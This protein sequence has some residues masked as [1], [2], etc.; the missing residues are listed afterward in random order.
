MQ[1]RAGWCTGR[2]EAVAAVGWL[3][4]MRMPEVAVVGW[5]A[6]MRMP[7]VAVVGWW[8]RMRMP[9]VA[10]TGSC[11]RMRMR[12]IAATRLPRC[13][14][15]A[16]GSRA[17]RACCICAPPTGPC[18]GPTGPVGAARVH[19]KTRA[20]RKLR[21]YCPSTLSAPSTRLE[22]VLELHRR[23]TVE[24]AHSRCC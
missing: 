8:A 17:H 19:V 23:T 12:A 22:N 2:R 11:V 15:Q 21:T 1:G 18:G 24:R 4:Q 13:R 20:A 14:M 7:A 6:R 5:W 10:V 16:A 9:A 3:P